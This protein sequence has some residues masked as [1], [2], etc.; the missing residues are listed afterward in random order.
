MIMF[1]HSRKSLLAFFCVLVC[2]DCAPSF[3]SS[4]NNGNPV[5]QWKGESVPLSW[6]YNLDGAVA[7]E[8]EWIFGIDQRIATVI[9]PSGPIY[10][11]P[12]FSSRVEVSE[13]TLRLLNIQEKDGGYYLFKVQL[14]TFNPRWI[15]DQAQLIVIGKFLYLYC[16]LHVCIRTV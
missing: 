1:L 3:T 6:S 14:T 15:L 7:E 12:E 13:N 11:D 5:Y 10:V 16:S 2:V 4:P 8:K 9:L